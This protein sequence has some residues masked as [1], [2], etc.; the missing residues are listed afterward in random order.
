MQKS[1]VEGIIIVFVVNDLEYS[2]GCFIQIHSSVLKEFINTGIRKWR[3]FVNHIKPL[4]DKNLN[5]V[6]IN[7]D[8]DDASIDGFG[9][10]VLLKVKQVHDFCS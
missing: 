1:F 6:A 5:Y 9:F 3:R 10:L 4:H 7:Q 2:I 8:G